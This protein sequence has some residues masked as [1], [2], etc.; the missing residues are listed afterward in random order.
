MTIFFARVDGRKLF[1]HVDGRTRGFGRG[2]F[3]VVGRSCRTEPPLVRIAC[4]RRIPSVQNHAGGRKLRNSCVRSLFDDKR[5]YDFAARFCVLGNQRRRQ[6]C[7]EGAHACKPLVF[8]VY[9]AAHRTARR[10]DQPEGSGKIEADYS[11]KSSGRRTKSRRS[12]GLYG[13]W[14]CS[15]PCHDKTY[16]N[17]AAVRKMVETQKDMR[18]PSSLIPYCPRC[19]KPMSMNLRSD[20]TFVEDEGWHKA[21]ERYGDFIATHKNEKILL[22]ELG[23]GSNTPG[24]IKYPFWRMCA[25]NPRSVYACINYGEALCPDEI[26]ER[27]ICIDG[28]IAS[29]L[30]ALEKMR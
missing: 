18:I 13:L 2:A 7:T 5:H 19:G 6:F 8:F 24:I 25:D 30:S 4:K 17:E 12:A 11:R 15:V 20:S 9:V 26:R 23:V 16:D 3:R 21:S 28:D 14:Q 27:S 10:H 1:F 29:V 22:L